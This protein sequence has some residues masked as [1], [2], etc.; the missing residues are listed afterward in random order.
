MKAMEEDA[1]VF[2]YDEVYDEIDQKKGEDVLRRQGKKAEDKR[3]YHYEMWIFL[4]CHVMIPCVF[5]RSAVAWI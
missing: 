4:R 2:Q 1:T 5:V 3:V